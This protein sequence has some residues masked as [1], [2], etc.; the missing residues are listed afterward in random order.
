LMPL[1][2]STYNFH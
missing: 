1:T 2:A